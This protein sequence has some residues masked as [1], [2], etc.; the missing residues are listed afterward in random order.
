MKVP[1]ALALLAGC[2]VLST[3]REP[4]FIVRLSAETRPR[5]GPGEL[6]ALGPLMRQP[7]WGNA[8]AGALSVRVYASAVRGRER[9]AG[10][11]CDRSIG[12]LIGQ[13]WAASRPQPT[14]R[15]QVRRRTGRRDRLC[16]AVN[17]TPA[18]VAQ[19]DR[20]AAF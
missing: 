8:D 15:C 14:L 17:S 9:L 1:H 13:H 5:P 6:P 3:G 18:P 4:E 11:R 20:A 7:R 2:I 19:L 12:P 10:A 16:Q